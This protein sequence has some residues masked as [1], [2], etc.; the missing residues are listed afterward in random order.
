MAHLTRLLHVLAIPAVVLG[1]SKVHASVVAV[2]SYDFTSSSRLT[3]AAAFIVL[4]WVAAYAVGLPALVRTIRAAFTSALVAVVIGVGG[5]SAAQLVLGDAL[6]PRFVVF[7]SALVLVP[8]LGAVGALGMRTMQ[9]AAQR[10][11]VFFVGGVAEAAQLQEDLHEGL[12]R[13]AVLLAAATVSELVGEGGEPSLIERLDATRANLLVLDVSAQA[14]PG[15]VAQA[16]SGHERGVRVRTLSLFYEEWLGKLPISELERVS[17]LFDVGELHRAR[18]ARMKRVFDIGAGVVGCAALLVA[19]P[20]VLVGNLLGNRGPL[21][22]RQERVGK[23]GS[24]FT[25][26]KFRTMTAGSDDNEW[27]TDSDPRITPFGRMLRVAHLDELPQAV[28]IVRGD[29]SLVGP[30]PEQTRYVEEL[31]EKLPFYRLRHLVRPGLTGWAQVK[32]GYAGD[33]RDALQKL[34]YEFFYLRRQG[35]A[36]DARIVARTLRHL[37]SGGGR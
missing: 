29:L 10:E 28:N 24:T 27:T 22:F 3:W 18:Y 7:G 16:A 20:F 30:R 17:L 1:L 32:Y 31:A 36:F 23:G 14:E 11:R 35:F 9:R 25:I 2:D 8:V 4:I 5:V 6:L 15:I 21:L 26:L 19:V 34:Q 33:E 12:E 37:G 13:P